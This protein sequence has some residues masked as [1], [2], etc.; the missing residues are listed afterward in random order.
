ME[1]SPKELREL[2]DEEYNRG[3]K[4]GRRRI[5]SPIID[6]EVASKTINDKIYNTYK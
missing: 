1:I 5:K 6:V 4:D 2:L 3:L